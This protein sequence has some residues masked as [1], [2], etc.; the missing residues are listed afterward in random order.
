MLINLKNLQKKRWVYLTRK[1]YSIFE[2][3]CLYVAALLII[4]LL[5]LWYF[6][7]NLE[8]LNSSLVAKL[9]L[10]ALTVALSLIVIAY[11]RG[12]LSFSA[13]GKVKRIL[14]N[15][16]ED[17]HFYYE[18]PTSRALISSMKI[19]FYAD[20][21]QLILEIYTFGSKYTKQMED[22]TEIFQTALNMTVISVEYDSPNHVTY[23]LED[24]TSNFIDATGLWNEK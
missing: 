20:N 13:S 6:L 12:P 3:I 19:R 1:R 11:I 9:Y 23:I 22:L 4:F 17:N 18:N 8:L 21:E 10:L 7:F 5:P 15:I 14:L 16:I 2:I 24:N